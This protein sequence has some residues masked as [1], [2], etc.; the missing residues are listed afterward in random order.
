MYKNSLRECDQKLDKD[1]F[2]LCNCIYLST[3]KADDKLEE[4]RYKKESEE[5]SEVWKF[6]DLIK[7]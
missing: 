3:A 5:S 1:G 4:S 7:I 6:I 2:Y